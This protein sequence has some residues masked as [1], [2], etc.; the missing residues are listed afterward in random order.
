MTIRRIALI[1]CIFILTLCAQV[2]STM[3]FQGK[4]T[5][6][7][8][9]GIDGPVDITFRLLKNYDPLT[10]APGD[11]LWLDTYAGVEVH[12]GLFDVILGSI[13]PLD[14]SFG[15]PCWV[16]LTIAGET[17][18]PRIELSSVAYAFRAKYADSTNAI[19]W[20]TLGAF[21]DSTHTHNLTLIGDMAGTGV[22]SGTLSVAIQ[23]GTIVWEDL[24]APVKDSI[25]FGS[26]SDAD[27]Q[28]VGSNMYA[29]PTGNVGI[30]TTSPG[31]KLEVRKQNTTS[32]IRITTDDGTGGAG[33][34]DVYLQYD[35]AGGGMSPGAY[36]WT[37]GIDNSDGQ[38]LTNFRCIRQCIPR[39]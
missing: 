3:N 15:E 28:V 13:T 8:G 24:S 30:G 21:V 22:V 25:R 33:P 34:G 37:T 4:L 36:I 20:D 32:K 26:G 29:I 1:S 17:L 10:D 27:W 14:L 38:R 9:V 19:N 7:D 5:D 31:A 39:I 16:E 12:K 23:S 6:L 11:T 35:L 2:P 18:I